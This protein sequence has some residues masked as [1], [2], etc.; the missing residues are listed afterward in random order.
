[1]AIR[2]ENIAVGRNGDARWLIE[3]VLT[4]SSDS[5]LAKGHQNLAGRTQLEDLMT[6]DHA[7]CILCRLAEDGL[8]LICVARPNISLP[9][10]CESM[11]KRE[12]PRTKARQKITCRIKFQNRRFRA[13]DAGG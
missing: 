11:G 3:C 9:V 4:I 2:H 10:H 13:A 12:H 1:M 6:S 7:I 8:V 5:L